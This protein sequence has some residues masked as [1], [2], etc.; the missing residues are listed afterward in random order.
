MF[1]CFKK[2]GSEK[3]NR[4][5]GG[6]SIHYRYVLKIYTD[7]KSWLLKAHLQGNQRKH[8]INSIIFLLYHSVG[9]G[10]NS[11]NVFSPKVILLELTEPWPKSIGTN[12]SHSKVCGSFMHF[13]KWC[14]VPQFDQNG[15]YSPKYPSHKFIM[16]GH[17]W[18]NWWRCNFSLDV[19]LV[20][21]RVCLGAHTIKV[22]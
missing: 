17:E 8:Q 15:W 20:Q 4:S 21:V 3:G 12:L 14:Y 10:K 22:W 9:G 18:Q 6:N 16:E 5:Q 1:H 2:R 13:N 7:P 11:L 19:F